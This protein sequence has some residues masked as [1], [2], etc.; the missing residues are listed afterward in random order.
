[1]MD[2]AVWL[3]RYAKYWQ[4][5]FDLLA[6]TLAEIDERRATAPPQPTPR[7]QAPSW[8]MTSR[9]PQPS[10]AQTIKPADAGGS[11]R[12]AKQRPARRRQVRRK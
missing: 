8:E 7:S 1:L 12:G 3:N 5:Q 2:A 4:G 6:A 11:A 9:E 10:E